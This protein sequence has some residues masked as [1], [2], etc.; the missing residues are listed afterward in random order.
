MLSSLIAAPM[1]E[2]PDPTITTSQSGGC[3]DG[4]SLARVMDALAA[5]ERG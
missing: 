5:Q 4:R 3:D 2:K 1:P